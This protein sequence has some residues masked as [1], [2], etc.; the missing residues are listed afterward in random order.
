MCVIKY[1]YNGDTCKSPIETFA[2]ASAVKT[3]VYTALII[4]SINKKTA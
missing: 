3:T 4:T 1:I 2:R